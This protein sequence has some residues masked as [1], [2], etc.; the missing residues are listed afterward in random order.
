MPDGAPGGASLFDSGAR[1]A[2]A[3]AVTPYHRVPLLLVP[4]SAVRT[5][6]AAIEDRHRDI[7][8]FPG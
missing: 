3:H 4:G 1:H 2:D 5:D 6:A 7:P 8:V